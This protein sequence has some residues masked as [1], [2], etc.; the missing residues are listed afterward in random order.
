MEPDYDLWREFTYEYE[1]DRLAIDV[2]NGSEE[3]RRWVD[4]DAATAADLETLVLADLVKFAREKPLP[5]EN[6]QVLNNSVDFVKNTIHRIENEVNNNKTVTDTE[7]HLTIE[8]KP[9]KN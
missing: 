4:D 6:D 7:T 8:T 2:I 1:N 3:L 5:L 9:V